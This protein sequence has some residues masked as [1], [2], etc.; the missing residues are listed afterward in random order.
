[1]SKSGN[2]E[3][4]VNGVVEQLKGGKIEERIEEVDPIVLV[5]INSEIEIPLIKGTD[6]TQPTIGEVDPYTGTKDL[7]IAAIDGKIDIPEN[8]SL[9]VTIT[10][11][12][13]CTSSVIP[14]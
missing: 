5:L 7:T 12:Y 6:Y 8:G 14:R 10:G 1:M 11:K 2:E 4:T 13:P 9:K 3:E